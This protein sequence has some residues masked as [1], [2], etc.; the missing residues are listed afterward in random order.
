[1]RHPLPS[2][3]KHTHLHTHTQYSSFYLQPLP[4]KINGFPNKKINKTPNRNLNFKSFQLQKKK[5][6][7][8]PL[9]FPS[10]L[11]IEIRKRKLKSWK[12]KSHFLQTIHFPS[13][14]Y[15]ELTRKSFLMILVNIIIF[16]ISSFNFLL[17]KQTNTIIH[18]HS[19]FFPFPSQHIIPYFP[20]HLDSP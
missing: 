3:H 16:S 5:K 18:S 13:P 8:F 9:P 7:E 14:L 6:K 12:T 4:M 10:P 20:F 15:L 1:M 17:F 19:H 11:Q 2:T